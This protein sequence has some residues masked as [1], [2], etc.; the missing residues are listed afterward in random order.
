MAKTVRNGTNPFSYHKVTFAKQNQLPNAIF[1]KT[2]AI[3]HSRLVGREGK[4]VN[5]VLLSVIIIVQKQ[6][7]RRL[8]DSALGGFKR[9]WTVTASNQGIMRRGLHF[10][11][12]LWQADHNQFPAPGNNCWKAVVSLI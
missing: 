4:S 10:A 9:K 3:S 2:L 7:I 8:C 6:P 1:P 11:C 12:T 5:N